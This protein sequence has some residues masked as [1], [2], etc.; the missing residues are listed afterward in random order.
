MGRNDMRPC[1]IFFHPERSQVATEI[2]LIDASFERLRRWRLTGWAVDKQPR[3]PARS[4][5]LG[6]TRT[7]VIPP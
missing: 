7:S 3:T 1:T 5:I 4:A 2:R 6:S